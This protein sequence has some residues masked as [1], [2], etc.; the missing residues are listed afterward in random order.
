MWVGYTISPENARKGYANEALAAVIKWAKA[1]DIAQVKAGIL[2][3]NIASVRLIEK[4]GFT[5]KA[6]EEGELVY[7]LDLRAE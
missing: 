3:G 5:F 2:P 1:R 6:E 7:S 4:S